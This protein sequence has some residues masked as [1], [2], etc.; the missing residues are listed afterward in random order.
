[1]ATQA[2]TKKFPGNPLLLPTVTYVAVIT[3]EAAATA[4]HRTLTYP[5]KKKPNATKTTM[6]AKASLVFTAP[7]GI[8]RDGSLIASM[9]RS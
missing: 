1:M 5:E 3:S 6:K 9:P 2:L 4:K 7:L 8:G